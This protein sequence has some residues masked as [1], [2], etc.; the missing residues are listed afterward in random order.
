MSI[1]QNG[2]KKT[3]PESVE[4][5]LTNPNQM[6]NYLLLDKVP[7]IFHLLMLRICYMYVIDC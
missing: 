2:I 4:F 1:R 6:R 7:T 5:F 3:T